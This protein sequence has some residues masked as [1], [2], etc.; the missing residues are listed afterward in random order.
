MDI[1][2]R[3]HDGLL[4]VK[5]SGKAVPDKYEKFFD[6]LFVHEGWEPGIS[7]LLDETDLDSSQLTVNDVSAIAG[8]C[9]RR[10]TE[11]GP[12]RMAIFV[13]RDLEYGMNRMW[14]TFVEDKWDVV[15]DVFRSRDEA[16]AWL[17]V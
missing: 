15:A 4:E 6:A 5:F 13:D 9:E 11:L 12:A 7:L 3:T 8:V 1:S 10:G 17:T 14:S 2:F 16:I